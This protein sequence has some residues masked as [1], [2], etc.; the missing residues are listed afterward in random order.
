[1]LLRTLSQELC[2]INRDTLACGKGLFRFGKARGNVSVT[3]RLHIQMHIDVKSIRSDPD[4]YAD[5]CKR[6]KYLSL[7][8]IPALIFKTHIQWL[9]LNHQLSEDRGQ[10]HMLQL[11]LAPNS[12]PT[13]TRERNKTL[14]NA[15]DLKA[16]LQGSIS[17][18]DRMENGMR[19]MAITLPN[20][21]SP[22]TPEGTRPRIIEQSALDP[23]MLESATLRDHVRIGQEFQ[24]L[25]FAM[26]SRS[27]GWG[28]YYLLNEAEML[29][30]ALIQYT[31][32]IVRASGFTPM[33]PPSLVYAEIGRAC[34]F[35]PKDS[36]GEEQI[37]KIAQSKSGKQ[38]HCLAGTA[39]IPFA[40]IMSDQR[41]KE[42]D[43]PYKVA[44]T[45][46]CYRA[47]AGARG[48]EARGLYRV[49]E[50]SKVE[51]FA[52]TK[53]GGEQKVFDEIV[54]VQKR[55]LTDL[56]LP[57]RV[58]EMPAPDLGAP[59]WR[60]QD[61]EVYF[62]SRATASDEETSADHDQDDRGWGEVTS[63]S[64]CL[65]YQSRRLGTRVKYNN[66][67]DDPM[68]RQTPF[69]STING[70][71]MAIPRVLAALLEHGWYLDRD[72]EERIRIPN[73]L[74][75]YMNGLRVISPKQTDP[76]E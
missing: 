32:S 70:T 23:A 41:I 14:K 20:L 4:L 34:G 13:K 57:F 46:R 24:L 58:L 6:R 59:A 22:E 55:I 39:E 73:C 18:L 30:Q 45:S 51:M 38:Q 43:L 61:I 36:R 71:A 11:S 19:N 26:A 29:E 2:F 44:G 66:K 10:L 42:K 3:R 35:Q 65:D 12:G 48:R 8:K 28:F 25:D 16:R 76:D 74:W 33:S 75:P 54:A 5:S 37:Y 68:Q 47:E 40:A 56:K 52:W 17:K 62:P 27:S 31:R 49:H 9:K 53:P 69:A 63:A 15:K 67:T 1:M 60:K 72:G 50:F 21:I 64:I 7:V